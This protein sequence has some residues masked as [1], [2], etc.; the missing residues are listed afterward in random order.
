M[1]PIEIDSLLFE[2]LV[3][4][5]TLSQHVL[6]QDRLMVHW[7]QIFDGLLLFEFAFCKFILV[8]KCFENHLLNL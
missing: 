1:F 2:L 3:R 5:T 6:A 7:F 4:L 8:V